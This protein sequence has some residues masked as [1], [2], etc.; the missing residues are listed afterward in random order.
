MIRTVLVIDDNE[1]FRSFL[2]DILLDEGFDVRDVSCPD[3]AFKLL[4]RGE[5]IDLI[6]CD[7]DMPFA[8]GKKGAE[9]KFSP[10]VGVETIK[11]L[12]WV[13]RWKPVIAMSA[14]PQD[15][16]QLYQKQIGAIPLLSKPF[17]HTDLFRLIESS[18][19]QGPV[20][21]VQ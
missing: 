12:M 5:E 19:Q 10:E 13:Y 1:N 6:L 3:E 7:L 14:L 15:R 9:Y 16:I 18:L 20:E 4:M 17:P 11:E 21:V 2:V 8:E